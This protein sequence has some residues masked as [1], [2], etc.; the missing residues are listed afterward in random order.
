VVL[1]ARSV[2]RSEVAVGGCGGCGLTANPNLM[3]M[4]IESFLVCSLLILRELQK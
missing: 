3:A 1:C 2:M 4:G